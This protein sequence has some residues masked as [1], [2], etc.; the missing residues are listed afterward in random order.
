MNRNLLK[1]INIEGM[2]KE[3]QLESLSIAIK[4]AEDIDIDHTINCGLRQ[5]K[6]YGY[7]P[8]QSG[9]RIWDGE[10]LKALEKE[11]S[12]VEKLISPSKTCWLIYP[13]EID[14]NLR[15]ELTKLRQ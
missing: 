7:R 9:L 6:V 1:A 4:L 11:S 14:S 8:Y 13:K 10:N 3:K 2:N 12:L 5:T 15:I